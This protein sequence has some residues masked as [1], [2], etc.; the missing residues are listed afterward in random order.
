M[1]SICTLPLWHPARIIATV[2]YVGHLPKAPGTW[3]SL[4]AFPIFIIYYFAAGALSTVMDRIFFHPVFEFLFL[5]CVI[6]GIIT[7]IGWWATAVYVKHSKDKDPKEVVIDEVV[8]QH[9]AIIAAQPFFIFAYDMP[10]FAGWA[11]MLAAFLF[12]RLFDIWKPWLVGWADKQ[13]GATGVML[14]D[15]IAGLLAIPFVFATAYIAAELF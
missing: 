7:S 9:L 1:S 14:D 3:G 12:F 6:W 8:G 13:E 2:F 4:A 5:V 11:S 10:A 15:I